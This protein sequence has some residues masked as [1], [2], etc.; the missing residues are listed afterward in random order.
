MCLKN[1]IDVFNIFI[2]KR[3]LGKKFSCYCRRELVFLIKVLDMLDYVK[4]CEL[5]NFVICVMVNK[6][7]KL[8]MF[9]ID[10]S[11]GSIKNVIFVNKF[12][13]I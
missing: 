10:I 12:F 8:I 5:W 3:N 6:F 11:K 4:L 2:I 7:F 13:K 1:I 9:V